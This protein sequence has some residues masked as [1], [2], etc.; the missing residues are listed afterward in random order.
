NGGENASIGCA[1]AKVAAECLF[2]IFYGWARFLPK[3]RF[4]SHNHSIRAIATLS[5]LFCNESSLN[6]I[7]FLWRSETLR[8]SD[9]VAFSLFDGR[10]AGA[11]RFPIDQHSACSALTETAA[12]FRSVQSHRVSK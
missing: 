10:D 11:R 1:P 5:G 7:G 8:R 3:K 6:G 4:S 9:C 12:E 2:D